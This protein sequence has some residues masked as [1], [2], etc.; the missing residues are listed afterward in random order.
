MSYKSLSSDSFGSDFESVG[1]CATGST[2]CCEEVCVVLV[3]SFIEALG[4]VSSAGAMERISVSSVY[5]RH[6]R[7]T[8]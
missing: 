4:G 2:A 6:S 3:E 1:V 7:V 8:G 5:L